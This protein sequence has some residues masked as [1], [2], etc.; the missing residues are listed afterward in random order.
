MRG[1]GLGFSNPVGEHGKCW[2]CVCVG[3]VYVGV[4]MGMVLEQGLEECGGVMSGFVVYMVGRGICI[5]C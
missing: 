4:G 2:T 5:L 1:F 3:V